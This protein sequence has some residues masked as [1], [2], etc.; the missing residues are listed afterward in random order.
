MSGQTE[1]VLPPASALRSSRCERAGLQ[2]AVELADFVETEALPG[3]GIAASHFWAGFAALVD[4]FT[5]TNRALLA[6]RD[7]L[8]QAIGDWYRDNSGQS[9]VPEDYL[10]EIGYLVPEPEKFAIE[11]RNVDSE[12]CAVAGPQLVVPVLNARFLLNAANA[13]WGSLY[14]ALYGTD[15]IDAALPPSGDYD[16]RRGASVVGWAKDFLDSCVP[17]GGM[18]WHDWRGGA[19]PLQDPSL[20]VGRAGENLLLRHNGLHIEIIIDRDHP[21]G[22]GDPAG[23]ADIRLEAALTAIVDL[24]DSVAAVDAADKT[25]AYRNWLGALR[26]DLTAS[27]TKAGRQI[28]RRAEPDRMWQTPD[29]EDYALPGRSL[30]LVRNVGHLMTT[31]AILTADGAP[32]FEGLLDAAI[33]SLCALHDVG[34]RGRGANSRAGSIYI[35]KPKMH[36]P[37]ECAF[38]NAV[39][40]AVEDLLELDRHTI[41]I[42]I[43]DEERRT[44][45]NLAACVHAV[46]DRVFF[47]NTGFLD[48]TGDEIHTSMLAGPM[49]RKADIKQAGWISAY[50]NRNVQIGLACGF[51][52][53]AQIGKG[54]WAAPDR[55]HEMLQQK[56]A[57]PQSG[58]STAWVPSPT[59]AVLHATHY[60]L[61]DVADRQ[62]ERMHEPVAALGHLLD[63]PLSTQPDWSAEQ[64]REELDNNVQGILGYVVRWIDSGVGCSKVPDIHDVGLMEDRATLRISSQHIA[65][66][67]LHGVVSDDDVEAA[68]ERMAVKVDEQNAQDTGYVAMSGRFDRSLA[69][70][71]ARALVFEGRS[72]PNGYTEPLLHEFR[73]RKKGAA[74]G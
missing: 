10:R 17:L 5:P 65:N 23:I 4:R 37:E 53:R 58:A 14:D 48:R 47:I 57:H 27:F 24:E 36:G 71:A 31:P 72:Q 21:I 73:L 60:H 9:G 2:V 41:K 13:R 25:A 6:R 67:L 68:F 45:A 59:A 15:A 46:K 43:M 18:S 12:I 7:E 1:A 50:E 32:V 22:S 38:A 8:Q 55:M 20:L 69:F 11:T 34:K 33:T 63:V 66:W 61:C 19:L 54:M 56:L 29:G 40:D 35:V 42:G 51:A 3:L 52:G 16:A 74:I 26:G 44:S 30:L 62:R 64:I 28:V 39:L 49:L 70:Q